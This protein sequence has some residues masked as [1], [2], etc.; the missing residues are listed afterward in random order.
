[1]V[2][3]NVTGIRVAGQTFKEGR[4]YSVGSV[5]GGLIG[6]FG[7]P[8]SVSGATAQIDITRER[9]ILYVSAEAEALGAPV[10]LD[11]KIIM[12]GRVLAR[13]RG[14]DVTARDFKIK[15]IGAGAYVDDNFDSAELLANARIRNPR[16][17]LWVS[18]A[19]SLADRGRGQALLRKLR[20]SSVNVYV[21]QSPLGGLLG[22]W[23]GA[24]G[25][26]VTNDLAK[27]LG[28]YGAELPFNWQQMQPLPL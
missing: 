2:I 22:G 24:S 10:N 20:P 18:K 19:A 23:L 14:A 15:K 26:P 6:S 12:D 8:V 5:L 27:G 9:L 28:D 16:R 7:L 21:S 17:S 25:V 1:M 3:D 11:A 13:R 4:N